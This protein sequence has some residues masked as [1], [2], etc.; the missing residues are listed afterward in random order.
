MLTVSCAPSVSVAWNKNL[1]HFN[2]CSSGQTAF[3]RS[4]KL[5]VVFVPI[6]VLVAHTT[7]TTI[8]VLIKCCA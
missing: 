8:E 4:V 1:L 3:T 5:P 6:T 7:P 2:G